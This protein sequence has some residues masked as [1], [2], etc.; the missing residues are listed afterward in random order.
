LKFLNYSESTLFLE[1]IDEPVPKK[2]EMLVRI[3]GCGIC[4][5][6]IGNVFGNSCKPTSKLG[7][8][9]VG[10]LEKFDSDVNP[11]AFSIGERVFVHHHAPCNECYFCK[12]GN[13]TMCEKF[14]DSLYPCGISEKIVIPEWIVKSDS[15]FRLPESL[16]PEDGIMIEPLACCIRGW[17]KVKL[18]EGDTILIFGIGPIGM[19]NAML[20]KIKGARKIF[21]VD[22]NEYRLEYNDRLNLGK[23]FNSKKVKIANNVPTSSEEF[24]DMVI[25]ATSDLSVL[26]DSIKII[27][28]GGIILI[29]GEPQRETKIDLNIDEIY[30]KE[31]SIITT[32]AAS[33]K[34]IRE[35]IE[36]IDKKII[37]V[38]KIVTHKF[39]IKQ[40]KEAIERI[41]RKK[42]TLKTMIINP[43]K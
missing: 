4:G 11:E 7:H 24:V 32:Y 6:D 17:K 43:E 42:D 25:I 36:L 1:D 30:S 23:S 5:S 21:C 14:T 29:F 15:I 38:K 19:I 34:E 13:E 27:R 39:L 12:K 18:L 10:I 31:I 8:E 2:G 37:N 16:S 33:N 40:S 20:A 41:F 3:E 9:F 28:K 35:A 26:N 22:I